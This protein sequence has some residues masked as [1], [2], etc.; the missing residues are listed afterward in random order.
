MV[1]QAVFDLACVT[2]NEV[3]VETELGISVQEFCVK[4]EAALKELSEGLD[5]LLAAK[6][7]NFEIFREQEAFCRR[8]L[9]DTVNSHD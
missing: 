6:H 2:A 8:L 5:E 9:L 3:K 4:R 7:P 1:N